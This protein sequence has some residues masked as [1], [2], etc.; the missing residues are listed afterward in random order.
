M[1]QDSVGICLNVCDRGSRFGRLS[2]GE[3]DKGSF[4]VVVLLAAVPDVA[5]LFQFQEQGI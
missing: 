2:R 5:G 1:E 4:L 3:T